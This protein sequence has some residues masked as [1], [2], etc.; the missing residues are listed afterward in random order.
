MA[1]EDGE[2]GTISWRIVG[3]FSGEIMGQSLIVVQVI[4]F[5]DVF[6]SIIK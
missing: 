6:G 1:V 5:F 2:V 3:Q 4:V